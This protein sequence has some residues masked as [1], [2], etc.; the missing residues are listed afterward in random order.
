M[1]DLRFC[2]V[3]TVLGGGNVELHVCL[4]L[5]EWLALMLTDLLEAETFTADARCRVVELRVSEGH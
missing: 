1:L 5:P 2:A 3:R 4:T